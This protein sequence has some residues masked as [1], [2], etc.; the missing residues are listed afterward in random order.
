MLVSLF[1]LT[2]N[3]QQS[4]DLIEINPDVSTSVL[5]HQGSC[6]LISSTSLLVARQ[7]S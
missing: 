5:V 2:I 4:L 7:D 1:P 6:Q 3:L